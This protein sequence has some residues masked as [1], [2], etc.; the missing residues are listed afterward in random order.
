MSKGKPRNAALVLTI[1]EVI[2]KV[3]FEI[4]LPRQRHTLHGKF[5]IFFKLPTT[6][7]SFF[8]PVYLKVI[9]VYVYDTNSSNTISQ[10]W[11]HI[12]SQQIKAHSP[13][14]T[15]QPISDREMKCISVHFT[16]AFQ[17]KLQQFN[18]PYNSRYS[19][20]FSSFNLADE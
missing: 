11:S 10:V 15:F 3:R 13:F 5:H 2:I 18:V 4:S 17:N 7:T 19:N 16:S 8:E 20:A 12:N 6:Y 1:T 14:N 9:Y